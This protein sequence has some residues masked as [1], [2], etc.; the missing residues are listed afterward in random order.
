MNVRAWWYAWQ[1]VRVSL[2]SWLVPIMIAFSSQVIERGTK[3]FAAY[4]TVVLTRS[5]DCCEL[6]AADSALQAET[7]LRSLLPGAKRCEWW[8]SHAG[9]YCI[10]SATMRRGS[11][12]T[13]VVSMLYKENFSFS[14]GRQTDPVARRGWAGMAW[15]GSLNR[16]PAVGGAV[17]SSCKGGQVEKFLAAAPKGL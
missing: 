17:V 13:R 12:Y 3:A 7:W 6:R 16:R 5:M 11:R 10:G 8:K 2:D 4:A 1:D 14:D 15:R 9:C